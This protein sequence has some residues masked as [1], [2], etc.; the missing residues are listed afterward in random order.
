MAKRK[1]VAS[2]NQQKLAYKLMSFGVSWRA[3]VLLFI[4]LLIFVV[5]SLLFLYIQDTPGRSI[6]TL[7]MT[8]LIIFDVLLLSVLFRPGMRKTLKQL[9][10]DYKAKISSGVLVTERV[11]SNKMGIFMACWGTFVAIGIILATFLVMLEMEEK[12]EMF[13]LLYGTVGL[14]AV[15]LVFW[16][17]YS[18]RL[19]RTETPRKS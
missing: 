17:F 11:V 4:F 15:F 7:L 9:E 3:L 19:N 6:W 10:R 1:S 18:K 2:A 12:M 8:P 16:P 5:G 14:V 13:F